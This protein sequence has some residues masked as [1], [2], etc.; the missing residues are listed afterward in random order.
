MQEYCRSLAAKLRS[1]G[2]LVEEFNLFAELKELLTKNEDWDAITEWDK[3]N[4]LEW[5]ELQ[6]T[7]SDIAEDREEGLAARLLTCLEK[8]HEKSKNEPLPPVLLVT[9]LEALHCFMR[10]GALENKLNG[11]FWYPT[12]FFYPGEKEG[13]TGLNFLGIN[14][15]DGNYRSEHLSVP[16]Y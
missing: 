5:Q 8:L 13:K 7:L 9:G 15:V 16:A 11:H 10:P 1:D 14:G 12:V 3:E 2:H 4:P 6:A